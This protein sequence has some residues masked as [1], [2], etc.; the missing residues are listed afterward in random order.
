MKR[1]W[2]TWKD[3][4]YTYFY[5]WV[6][7]CFKCCKKL[8]FSCTRYSMIFKNACKH[9]KKLTCGLSLWSWCC[10]VMLYH[11]IYSLNTLFASLWQSWQSD[12]HTQ[13][14]NLGSY[15]P[16]LHVFRLWKTYVQRN[17]EQTNTLQDRESLSGCFYSEV[18]IWYFHSCFAC[19]IVS[20]PCSWGPTALH[21][22]DDSC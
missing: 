19:G 16:D 17:G 20:R 14:N 9:F 2:K 13:N 8:F 10:A 15:Q 11:P 1:L 5:F 18:A 22:S 21:V 12:R 3:F 6:S 4:S 7:F